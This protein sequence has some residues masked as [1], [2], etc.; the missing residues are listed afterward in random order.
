MGFDQEFWELMPDSIQWAARTGRDAWSQP[1]FG[2]PDTI[3][4]CRVDYQKRE[5]WEPEGQD[6]LHVATVTIG[7]FTTIN[8]RPINIGLD[9]QITLPDGQKPRIRDIRIPS[10]ETGPHHIVIELGQAGGA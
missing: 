6:V 8:G 7:T 10:D 9:D 5:T 3:E 4:H 2:T 1:T